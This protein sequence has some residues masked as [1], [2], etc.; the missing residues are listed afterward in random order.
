MRLFLALQLDEAALGLLERTQRRLR[1][2]CDGWRWARRGAFHLTIRFLGEVDPA[3]DA[4]HRE[5]WQ[6]AARGDGPLRLRLEGVG[7]FPPR[8][9]PRV[10][11]L[12]VHDETSD[13][14]L[15]GL[16]ERVEQAARDAGFAPETRPF[17][18]HLTLARAQR[19]ARP[20]APPAAF[21][22][23]SATLA[24]DALS[25]FRSELRPEGARYTRLDSFSLAGGAARLQPEPGSR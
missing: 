22:S 2:R 8:G 6:A 9:R 14:R 25:L 13:G 20:V 24:P 1:D 5:I 16:A 12:G 3:D 7:T 23:G 11:W 15:Y 4:R 17:R 19:G 18:P 21:E 10:L